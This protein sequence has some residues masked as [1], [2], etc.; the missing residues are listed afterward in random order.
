M[1]H[2]LPGN[3]IYPPNETS[4]LVLTPLSP[5]DSPPIVILASNEINDGTLFLNGLTQNIIVLYDLFES[6]GYRAYIFENINPN[7]A[8][9]SKNTFLS[10]Y[11]KTNT[12]EL[13]KQTI[14]P[15]ITA[16]IEIGMSIDAMTR[17]YLRSIGAK[18]VKL[19]LG[20]I[21]NID[22]ETI[23]CYQSAFFNHHIVGELDEI[24][25]SP[26]Y[27][28]HV[29][30]AAVLNRV[31]LSKG[32]TVP[33]VWDPCFVNAY[34]PTKKPQWTPPSDWTKGD[35]V[36]MDPNIS[37]QKFSFYSILLAEAFYRQTPTWKGQVHVINGDR[38]KLSPNAT[39]HFLSQ[40][41]LYKEGRIQL[42]DRKRIHEIMEQF[43]S[44]S[45]ITHQ[46]NNEYNYATLELMYCQFPILHNS[47]GWSN[48]GYYYSI[49]DWENAVKRLKTVLQSHKE[50]LPVYETHTANL[51][52]KH[53]IHHPDIRAGWKKLLS[54][55]SES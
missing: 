26:H 27:F 28:Q 4:D 17:N 29:E 51:I 47:E 41:T 40:L 8:T 16:F 53:S 1:E 31:P 2:Y 14:P 6:M 22:I 38:L 19:Y 10:K 32:K 13:V 33:Y 30:Y 25:T 11:R 12:N 43:P 42:H 39:K 46:W 21:L 15:R 48:F 20:N 7:A 3:T 50:L 45:F 49:N 23:H 18:M 34:A 44:A 9:P 24:W 54:F 35:L 52:W 36:I 5:S 37:F 55:Q